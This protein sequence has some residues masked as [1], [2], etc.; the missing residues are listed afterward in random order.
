M[1]HYLSSSQ[2]FLAS[3]KNKTVKR[4]LPKVC[5]I[6]FGL[7][8]SVSYGHGTAKGPAAILKASHQVEL[9]DEELWCEP[10]RSYEL[11]TRKAV[12]IKSKIPAALDQLEEIVAEEVASGK[13]PF[14]FG[15]EHSLTPGAIR[16]LIKKHKKLSLLHFDA[17]A[18][19]RDG[20]AGEHYSHAAALRRCL[21]YEGVRVTSIGIRNLSEPEARFYEK[22]RKRIN[23][24]WGKDRV[25]WKMADIMRS[26]G[27]DPVYITFDIDGFDSSVMPAT[28]TPEPGGF[29]W[30]DAIK[31]LRAA[32]KTKNV[33]GA[34]L[35]ELAPRKELHS[36]D[37]LAAKLA[38]K[39][40][41]YRFSG[42]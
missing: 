12:R 11:F 28:G 1:T 22:N 40:L 33:V 7:E 20:Y 15:G 24:F 6:P 3:P 29:F 14:V 25:Q 8:N 10:H 16:P 36:C 13:F 21:D 23:I 34:D 41:A 5:I 19:L 18:D 42:T 30:D 37:F 31:I 17:H 32:C 2:G 39:I 26:L 4:G 9:F 35:L 27:N 38:F